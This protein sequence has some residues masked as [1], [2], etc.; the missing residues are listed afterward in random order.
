MENLAHKIN[1]H[2]EVNEGLISEYYFRNERKKADNKWLREHRK[3]VIEE[4]QKLNKNKVDYGDFRVSMTIPDT[5]K[6]D[7]EKILRFTES[8]GYKDK[9]VKEV[10]D[11]D[12]LMELLEKD[13]I[14]I[15]D[16]KEHAWIE[17]TGSPRITVKK[18]NK[19]C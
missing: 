17:S 12:K 16:L 5:S 7:E 10:L 14:S 4:L 2:S 11:E 1:A 13:L 9:V 19:K 6:F 15:E 18:L 3:L 8:K